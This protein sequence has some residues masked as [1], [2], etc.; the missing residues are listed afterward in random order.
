MKMTIFRFMNLHIKEVIQIKNDMNDI[1][2]AHEFIEK[3]KNK[4]Q[5]DYSFY[6]NSYAGNKPMK[7]NNQIARFLSTNESTLKII[8]TRRVI[9]FNANGN[10]STVQEWKK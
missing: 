4:F 8:K 9:S 6:L 5:E 3:F 2:N 10:K 7:V 1:F